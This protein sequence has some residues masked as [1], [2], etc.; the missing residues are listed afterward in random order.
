MYDTTIV[1]LKERRNRMDEIEYR[2]IHRPSYTSVIRPIKTDT[3]INVY[4]CI[5]QSAIFDSGFD[6]NEIVIP[7][8]QLR[9]KMDRGQIE[10]GNTRN[11]YMSIHH[12]T[13]KRTLQDDGTTAEYRHG[14]WD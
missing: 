9:A 12:D 7:R 6:G 5:G 8:P 3:S 13:R 2:S 4:R 10:T 14:R 11:N 1:R